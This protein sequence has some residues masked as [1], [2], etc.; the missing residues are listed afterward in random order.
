M[1]IKMLQTV[2]LLNYDDKRWRFYKGRT[3]SA[4]PATN[5]PEY[6]EKG[7]V[8]VI[9]WNNPEGLLIEK[10]EYQIVSHL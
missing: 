10:G 8:F 9:K 4:I 7:K 3:Y 5:Q 6:K 2:H 1:K